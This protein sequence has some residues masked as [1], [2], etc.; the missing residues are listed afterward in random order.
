MVHEDVGEKD[1]VQPPDE[2][3][4]SST[5][6]SLSDKKIHSFKISFPSPPV[7]EQDAYHTK[8]SYPKFMKELGEELTGF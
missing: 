5:F 2:S 1:C 4:H 7:F 3:S 8:L 6:N